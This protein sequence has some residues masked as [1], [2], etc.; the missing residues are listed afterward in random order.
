MSHTA[1][2]TLSIANGG[3]D[4]PRLSDVWSKGQVRSTLGAMTNLTIMAPAALTGV[5]TVQVAP[6]Y[7]DV[8]GNFRPLQE[9]GADITLVAGKVTNI[10]L[11]AFGDLR[12]HSAGAEGAQRDF[13]LV[14]QIRTDN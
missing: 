12:I 13:D 9:G 3:T 6:K 7:A 2:K 4:S 5:I 1:Q 8:A 11:A 14:F 10:K